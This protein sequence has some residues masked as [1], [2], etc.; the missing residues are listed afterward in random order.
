MLCGIGKE[1]V[2]GTLYLFAIYININKRREMTAEFQAF[3][4]F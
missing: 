2:M 3:N 1:I 4:Q